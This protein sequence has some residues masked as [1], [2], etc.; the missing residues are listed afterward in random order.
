MQGLPQEQRRSKGAIACDYIERFYNTRRQHSR[1]GRCPIGFE[2]RGRVGVSQCHRTRVEACAG[3]GMQS[4]CDSYNAVCK[5][6]SCEIRLTAP[7]GLS[8][9]GPELRLGGIQADAAIPRTFI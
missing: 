5:D 1:M 4:R 2:R 7:T 9:D 6:A 8:E 3:S